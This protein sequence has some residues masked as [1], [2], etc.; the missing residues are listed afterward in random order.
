MVN[1]TK[2]LVDTAE[3]IIGRN[4]NLVLTTKRFDFGNYIAFAPP[5]NL[6]VKF[7]MDIVASTTSL[8]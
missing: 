6:L 2:R 4:K 3:V 8:W 5:L 7:N 1:G